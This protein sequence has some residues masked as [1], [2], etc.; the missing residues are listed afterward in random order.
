MPPLKCLLSY[1]QEKKVKVSLFRKPNEGLIPEDPQ[2]GT[3]TGCPH[4]E[5]PEERGKWTKSKELLFVCFF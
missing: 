1:H 2:M 3:V 4:S 5:P